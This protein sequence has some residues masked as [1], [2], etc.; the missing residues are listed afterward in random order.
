MQTQS[1]EQAL[2]REAVR[3][4]AQGHPISDI[5]RDLQ[6]TRQ[7]L[8]KWWRQFQTHPETDF[9]DHSRAPH[10]SPR[11]TSKEVEQ[12]IVT[13]RQALEAGATSDTRYGLI[14]ARSIQGRLEHLGITHLP[15]LRT[16]GRVLVKHNLTHALG[17]GHESAYYP[18]PVAWETNSIFATDIITKHLRGG[19]S[20]ENF[21][22]MDLFSHD[23][24]L[25]PQMEKNS[26]TARKHLLQ[27]WIELGRPFL[28]QFDNESS[29]NGGQSH[30]RVFGRVVRSCLYCQVEPLFTPLYE[31][32][33][34]Y[35]IESFHSL[36]VAAFWSRHE[37]TSCCAVECELPLFRRWY[38]SEYRP[39]AL[40][41]RTV[42]QVRR[43]FHPPCIPL[44]KLIPEGRLPLTAGRIHVMRKVSP[45]GT[46]TLLNEPWT[47]G[48]RWMGEYVRATIDTAR[49]RIGFWHKQDEDADWRCLKTNMFRTH[50]TVHDVVPPFRRK[51]K[52][53]LDT[54]PG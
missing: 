49:Q 28:H 4:L 41:G 36:W 3:R 22:T 39:P 9:A 25:S 29:F 18:W 13:L 48:K 11:R 8:N 38:R 47:V 24:W 16:I 12:T 23:V 26:A 21:H 44:M 34:N 43:G 53:C 35:Q 27:S 37:F 10:T 31:A 32:K 2:R 1:S 17:Q 51:C 20:I 45:Q 5:C 7:W 14:C 33:R 42:K 54:L 40:D 52:R 15:S 30:K 46:I 50:E 19:V 6:R